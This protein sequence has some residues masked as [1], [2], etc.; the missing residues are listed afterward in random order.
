MEYKKPSKTAYSSRITQNNI[1]GNSEGREVSGLTNIRGFTQTREGVVTDRELISK[2]M[3]LDKDD[4]KHSYYYMRVIGFCAL[5]RRTGKRREELG[6][7][8][9]SDIE[10]RA[11]PDSI[12]IIFTLMKK[13]KSSVYYTE[14]S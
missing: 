6:L 8:K 3:A 14:S 1:I 11:R 13:R 7:L 12:R 10:T 5:A 2:I 4:F 9:F